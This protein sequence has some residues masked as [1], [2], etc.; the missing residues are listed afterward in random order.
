MQFVSELEAHISV[1]PSLIEC[2]QSGI[3]RDSK[4]LFS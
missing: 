3:N 1:N 2:H 4:R